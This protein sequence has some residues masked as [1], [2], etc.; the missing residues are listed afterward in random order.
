MEHAL[1]WKKARG[2]M[3]T[4]ASEHWRMTLAVFFIVLALECA[5]AY[6]ILYLNDGMLHDAL[7]RTAN[8]FFVLY[9]EPPKLASIGFVWNPLPSLLQLP[10]L[11]FAKAWPPLA[12]HGLAGGFVTAVF[13]AFNA[14][15]LYRTLKYYKHGTALTLLVIALFTLHPF[16][17][18]Y[19][20]N[21]MSEMPFYTS[22]I[23]CVCSLLKWMERRKTTDLLQMAV[24]LVIGF[25]CRYEVF[26]FALGLGIALLVIIFV[27]KDPLSQFNKTLSMK[28]HYAAATFA[29]VFLPVLYSALIWVFLNWTLMGDPLYFISSTYSNSAQT[30]NDLTASFVMMVTSPGPA[31]A[32]MGVRLIPFLLP[33]VPVV[34]ERALT[35]R[36]LKADFW[37]FISLI[38]TLVLFHYYMLLNGSSYGWL[39]FSSYA[40]PVVAAL[41]PYELSKLRRFAKGATVAGLVFCF[42][43]SGILIPSVYFKSYDLAAEEFAAFYGTDSAFTATQ[44]KAAVA[45]NEKYSEGLI[46]ADSVGTGGV[47]LNLEHPEH[48]VI[49]SSDIFREALLRPWDYGIRYILIVNPMTSGRMDQINDVHIGLYDH[50]ADW[51]FLVE[52]FGDVRI[53]ALW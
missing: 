49:N 28:T 15:Y 8:A 13:A 44:R 47:I 31:A 30:A 2:F 4:R 42:L 43:I 37:I 17:F 27:M 53:Y 22:Q 12:T 16:I 19:G 33:F 51:C 24:A 14:A 52:D 11:L 34:A 50:G 7:S 23:V 18:Y 45:I 21:G 5:G 40:L 41:L 48:M 36:L 38:F 9:T 1:E 29:A 10:L 32:Y 25:F 26:A 39:R 46:L 35:R 3:K 20:C 6:I